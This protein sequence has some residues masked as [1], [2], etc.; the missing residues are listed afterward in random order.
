MS[1]ITPTNTPK[2]QQTIVDVTTSKSRKC[3]FCGKDIEESSN[4][5]KLFSA[6]LSKTDACILLPKKF[7]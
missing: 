2:K 6:D 1:N 4:R 3:S 5:R 7:Q